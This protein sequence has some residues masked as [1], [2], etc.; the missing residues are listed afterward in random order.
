MSLSPFESP[1]GISDNAQSR[2]SPRGFTWRKLCLGGCFTALACF[3]T[4]FL[5]AVSTT[6]LPDE[7]S[8]VFWSLVIVAGALEAGIVGGLLVA[9]V[10]AIGWVFAP[11]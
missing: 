1:R 4:L 5:L 9:L 11:K 10:G 7:S 8:V 2:S 6:E 3:V